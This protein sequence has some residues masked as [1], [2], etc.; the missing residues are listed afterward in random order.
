VDA[1]PPASAR[2]GDG[3]F[4]E[5]LPA[6]PAETAPASEVPELMDADAPCPECGAIGE[7]EHYGPEEDDAPAED[8]PCPECGIVGGCEHY[9]IEPESG[10]TL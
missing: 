1:I 9:E 5:L 6:E 4:F 10:V 3:A 2:E 7:C 8:E